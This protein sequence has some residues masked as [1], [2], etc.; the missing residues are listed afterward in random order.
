MS[1]FFSV[2]QGGGTCSCH[3]WYQENHAVFIMGSVFLEKAFATGKDSR[4]DLLQFFW[5]PDWKRLSR[6]VASSLLM[7]GSIDTVTQVRL[8]VIKQK[9]SPQCWRNASLPGDVLISVYFRI[10]DMDWGLLSIKLP[11]FIE[12]MRDCAN[13]DTGCRLKSVKTQ[14]FS[15]V[16][17]SNYD[18]PLSLKIS[19]WFEATL[20]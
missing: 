7:P 10:R 19:S 12:K 16:F 14:L 8:L 4:L 18:T 6:K 2:T 20:N 15:P 13:L 5:S 1:R 9:P 3:R 11:I 17:S